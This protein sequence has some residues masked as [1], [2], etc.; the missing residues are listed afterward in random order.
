M[1]RTRLLR[2]AVLLCLP[3]GVLA[4]GGD[5]EKSED[6]IRQDLSENLQAGDA[7]VDEDAADCFAD[8]IIDEVGLERLRDIDLSDDSPQDG[9]DEDLAAAAIRATEE[10]DLSGLGG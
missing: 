2:T 8:V 6:E 4:C 1:R 5:K 7:G 3:L 9:S 10:C